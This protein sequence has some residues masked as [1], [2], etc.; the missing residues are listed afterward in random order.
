MFKDMTHA[1]LLLKAKEMKI[2]GASQMKKADLL[3][4]V[5]KA[6]SFTVG[7]TP[8]TNAETVAAQT[9]GVCPVTEAPCLKSCPP[10]ECHA[11][12]VGIDPAASGSDKTVAYVVESSSSDSELENHPKFA[13]FKKREKI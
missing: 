5:E 3:A 10:G 9:A 2:A 12:Q 4:A 1:Q 13:K 6:Y 11:P 7:I 8:E